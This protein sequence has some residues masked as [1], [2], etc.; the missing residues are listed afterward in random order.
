MDKTMF[1]E[2]IENSKIKESSSIE[3]GIKNVQETLKKLDTEN[4]IKFQH[5]FDYY[6][7]MGDKSLIAGISALVQGYAFYDECIDTIDY[8]LDILVFM[9]K[10]IFLKTLFNPDSFSE[11]FDLDLGG[12]YDIESLNCLTYLIMETSDYR[13]AYE[14]YHLSEK[15]KKS[16]KEDIIYSKN[17]DFEWEDIK[18]LKNILPKLFNKSKKE[19]DF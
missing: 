10:D 18:E 15:E 2:I 1:W 14:K 11:I 7:E 13:K 4:I 12:E 17:I 3:Q 6:K 5:Y 9:G 8:F 19:Y 16:I